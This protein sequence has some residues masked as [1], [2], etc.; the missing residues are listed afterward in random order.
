[1]LKGSLFTCA[2]FGRNPGSGVTNS[3]LFLPDR[4]L[5]H[6]ALRKALDRRAIHGDLFN[7]LNKLPTIAGDCVSSK[8]QTFITPILFTRG[9]ESKLESESK[10]PRV[11]A[12]SKESESIK[13]PRL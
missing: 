7:I 9:A 10:S 3:H 6:C 1:M 4:N 12:T 2:R 13:L 5:P 11:V 8:V